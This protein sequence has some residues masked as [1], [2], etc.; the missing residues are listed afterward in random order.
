MAKSTMRMRRSRSSRSS[1]SNKGTRKHHNGSNIGMQKFER[2]VVIKFIQM[3]NLVK[4]FH[5]K[6]RSYATHKATD[7]LYANLNTNI[8]SF[9][10]VL[11]GKHGDRVNLM[12]VKNIAL[13]DF[14]SQNDF[15]RELN[16]FKNYLVGLN[17]NKALKTMSNSDLYNIRDEILANINQVLYLLTF[18]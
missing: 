3:L 10:E 15:R 11:L 12:H 17:D 4:L 14:K 7:E 5:W 9:I 18:K 16:G 13:K 6:T 8:D 1:N 2:E